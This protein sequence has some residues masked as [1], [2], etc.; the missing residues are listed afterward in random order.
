MSRFFIVLFTL[1]SFI[2]TSNVRCQSLEKQVIKVNYTSTPISQY[3]MTE[4]DM[5]STPTKA[6]IYRYM[7]GITKYYSLYI[8]MEDRSSIYMLDSVNQIRPRGWGN[9]RSRITLLDSVYFTI[10]SPKKKTFK[11]EWV[12]NQ[13]FFSEG[14]VGDI[15][16]E[17]T[18]EEKTIDGLKSYKAF[19]KNYPMLTAWYTKDI[20]VSNGPS[21]YQGL[22]GLVIITEDYSNTIQINKVSYLDNLD[23]FKRLYDK[24]IKFFKKQKEEKN[25][26]I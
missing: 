3:R 9:T 8:N 23:K 25:R 12:M 21:I 13:T 14:N 26:F 7:Q 19:S 16:W 22:P 24:K 4:D 18:D 5:N 20:P 11:H 2:L 15:K 1:L 6:S 10:K 17:L